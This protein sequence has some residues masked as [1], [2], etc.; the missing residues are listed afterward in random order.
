MFD[1]TTNEMGLILVYIANHTV[2]LLSILLQLVVS[3]T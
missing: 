1:Y 2:G 3:S